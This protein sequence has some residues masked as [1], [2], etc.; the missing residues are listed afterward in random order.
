MLWLDYLSGPTP[1]VKADIDRVIDNAPNGSV[2]LVTVNV[3]GGSLG[4]GLEG[5][6]TRLR[7]LFG[8]VVAEDAPLIDF[9]EAKLPKL[10][11]ECVHTYIASRCQRLAQ[12]PYV[13]AFSMPY[14]DNA[15][16]LTV[17][18]VLPGVRQ[19]PGVRA[20]SERSDWPGF[21]AVP[22]ETPPLTPKELTALQRVLPPSNGGLTDGDLARLGFA[23]EPGMLDV[24]SAHYRRYPSFFQVVG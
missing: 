9:E 12:R 17:G 7:E 24:Y 2:L 16:M 10:V 19:E 1:D 8:D 23:L 6:R 22:I 5:R 21:P 11:A 15:Q 18:G 13:P 20:V 14:R 3:S 4:K